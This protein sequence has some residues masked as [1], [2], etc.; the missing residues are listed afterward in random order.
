MRQ[1]RAYWQGLIVGY[2]DFRNFWSP[3]SWLFGWMLRITS[4]SFA[5]VLMGR[6]LGS[7]E[8]QNYLLI[9][10]AV[11]VGATSALWASNASGW[12]RFD[13]T[14]PLMVIAPTSLVPATMGRTSIWL[15]NG[16]AT[17]LASFSVLMLA[18]GY[19]PAWSQCL[20]VLPLLALVCL[21]SYCFALVLGAMVGRRIRLRNLVLDVTGTLLMAWCGVSVPVSFWPGWVRVIA[22]ALP[23]THGL[24][25]IRG[26]LAD[27]PVRL[28]LRET[29]LEATIGGA[30]LVISLLLIDRVAESGRSDGSLELV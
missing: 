21:S 14:H 19:S 3:R 2:Y 27:A 28:V 6:M 22:R 30:W 4:N 16:V 10:N 25:A 26:V 11:A 20:L 5:W 15:I 23:L 13:G 29:V 1:L 8:K 17:S 7:A 18:F 12:S 9:G 24:A